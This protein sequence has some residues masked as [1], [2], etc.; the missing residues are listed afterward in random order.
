M[1]NG[2]V[3]SV[4]ELL[5]KF[6][7]E[8]IIIEKEVDP[9]DEIAGIQQALQDSYALLFTNVKGFPDVR[10]I[11]NAFSRSERVA[12]MFDVKEF[13]EL[14]FKCREAMKNPLPP[15]IVTD[16]PCQEVVHDIQEVD[17]PS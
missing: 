9:I 14:K 15:Q 1:A 2:T 11:G 7:D 8:F 3:T 4:R 10:I 17:L 16:A 13:R 12:R 6:E 5:S